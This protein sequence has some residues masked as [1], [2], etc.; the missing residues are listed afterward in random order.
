MHILKGKKSVMIFEDEKQPISNTQLA[1]KG[2][3]HVGQT[4][5]FKEKYLTWKCRAI[6]M[7]TWNN[8]KTY[9]SREFSNYETLNKLT[10]CDAGFGAHATVEQV[11]SNMSKFEEAMDILAYVATT[12]NNILCQ[13]TDT[14]SKLTQQLA[15]GIKVITQL[16]DENAK[17]LKIVEVSA[18]ADA[19][20]DTF[21][22]G[23]G[24]NPGKNCCN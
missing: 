24:T 4:G 19:G 23:G 21:L 5:F 18:G 3:L 2:Q 8:F 16:Q 10:S 17:L 6:T 13:L 9:W 12:S 7:K 20:A 14:N 22:I 15:D 11:Q 1:A